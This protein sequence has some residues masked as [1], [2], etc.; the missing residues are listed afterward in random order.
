MSNI[1]ISIY[2][3][4]LLASADQ[5]FKMYQHYPLESSFSSRFYPSMVK[6]SKYVQITKMNMDANYYELLLKAHDRSALM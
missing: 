2:P 6:P 3:F 4:K 5:W 1:H